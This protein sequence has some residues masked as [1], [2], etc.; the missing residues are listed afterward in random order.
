MLAL[1]CASANTTTPIHFTPLRP[2]PPLDACAL[3]ADIV[4]AQPLHDQY[5][6]GFWLVK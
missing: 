1:I 5:K 2:Y 3:S 6:K 4:S